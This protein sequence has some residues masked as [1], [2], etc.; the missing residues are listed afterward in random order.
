MM[1]MMTMMINTTVE[2]IADIRRP[3]VVID[4]HY[5]VL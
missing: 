1:M 5:A 4:L 2:M 3:T